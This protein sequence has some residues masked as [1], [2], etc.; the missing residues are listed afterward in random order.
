MPQPARHM[1]PSAPADHY[2]EIG[3]TRLRYRDT[4]RGAA[5]V[6]VHGWTLDSDMWE[7]QSEVL[8]R[9]FRMIRMDRR[10]HGLSQGWPSLADD[11]SDIAELL[12][13]LEVERFALLGMS[14]GARVALKVASL[15]PERVTALILDGPPFIGAPAHAA[16][17]EIPYD[18][19]RVIAQTEGLTAFRREWRKN[20]LTQLRSKNPQMQEL[21]DKILERYPGHDLTAANATAPFT[22]DLH[23]IARGR[24]PTL[25]LSGEYDLKTRQ[26]SA[27]WL[28]AHLDGSIHRQIPNAG[29]LSG[30][31]NPCVY[32]QVVSDFF[33]RHAL[34][35]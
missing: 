4:G 18:Q 11:A 25:I 29:H 5:V 14:Q 17:P 6:L 1:H 9:S 12:R 33:M 22:I 16:A 34:G 27:Q 31:D 35:Q 3:G 10:G 26:E 7:P 30:M 21:L 32:N 19:F 28:A 20:P 23:S 8:S 13:I 15:S 24:I 2:L